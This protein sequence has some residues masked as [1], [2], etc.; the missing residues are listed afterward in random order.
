MP[1]LPT[2]ISLTTGHA[3]SRWTHLLAISAPRTEEGH[4]YPFGLLH[5]LGGG[6]S[7]HRCGVRIR[8]RYYVSYAERCIC[9][10]CSHSALSF[11][12][13]PG[14]AAGLQR[15]PPHLFQTKLRNAAPKSQDLA[16]APS[17]PSSVKNP[18]S[19]S[20]YP[21]NVTKWVR[22]TVPSLVQVKSSLR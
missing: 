20:L 18:P 3:L 22:F 16:L 1:S 14:L 21:T 12:G 9:Y 7:A 5:P 11:T 6:L 13:S 19:S 4:F 8:R 17:I 10:S 15:I 2:P